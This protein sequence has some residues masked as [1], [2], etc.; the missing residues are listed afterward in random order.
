M[1]I[2]YVVALGM[3]LA[4]PVASLA[5]PPAHAPA[6]GYRAKHQYVY[7]PAHRIYHEPSN[8]LWF[9]MNGGSWSFGASLPVHL[10]QFTVGGISVELDTDRPYTQQAYVEQTYVKSKSK[11]GPPGHSKGK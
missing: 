5:D 7:Y 11:G 3:A 1:K 2:V 9:W 6:H 4:G 8:Q 10:Q